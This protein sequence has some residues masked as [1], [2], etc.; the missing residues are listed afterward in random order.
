MAKFDK[1]TNSLLCVENPVPVAA[2]EESTIM[3]TDFNDNAASTFYK[4]FTKMVSDPKIKII[5]I[6]I[7]SY[8]G[9][10]YCLFSML[11]LIKASPKPVATIVLGKAMSCGA[12]LA[13]AGTPGL[14]FMAPMADL[15]IHEV[16]GLAWGKDIEVKHTSAQLSKMNRKLLRSLANYAKKKDKNYFID[17]IRARLHMDWY[18]SAKECKLEGIVDHIGIPN[19]VKS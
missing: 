9:E 13:A 7:N 4:A 16:A 2:T 15:L 12:I 17:G 8:G 6:V 18:L 10:V 11:D 3:V 1:K 5:P 19:L 14:R